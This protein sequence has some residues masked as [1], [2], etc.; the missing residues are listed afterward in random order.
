[1]APQW[2][3]DQFTA[4]R[5]SFMD[6]ALP[7]LKV[8]CGFGSPLR[9]LAWFLVFLALLALTINDIVNLAVEY[10]KYPDSLNIKYEEPEGGEDMPMPAVT[11]CNLNPYKWHDFCKKLELLLGS[12]QVLI[13]NTTYVQ[14]VRLQKD[15]CKTGLTED[16]RIPVWNL[17]RNHLILM[18]FFTEWSGALQRNPSTEEDMSSISHGLQDM[19]ELASFDDAC[20]IFPGNDTKEQCRVERE[21]LEPTPKMYPRYGK[22]LCFFCNHT[23]D[24]KKIVRM[25]DF[26]GPHKGLMLVLKVGDNEYLPF[27]VEAGFVIA[28]HDQGVEVDFTKDGVFIQPLTT[29]YIGVSRRV[30]K[31]LAE[32]Y[33]NPCRSDWPPYLK[34]LV[35]DTKKYTASECREVC[36]Q[37][38]IQTTLNCTSLAY[39]IS[40]VKD[41]DGYKDFRLQTCGPS[42]D[43]GMSHIRRGMYYR[44]VDC[45]CKNVCEETNFD[46]TTSSLSWHPIVQAQSMEDKDGTSMAQVYVYMQSNLIS[47]RTKVGKMDVREFVSGIGSIMGMYLGYSFLFC[48]NILDV[49]GLRLLFVDSALPGLK[50]ICGFGSPARRAAWLLVFLALFGLTIR[51]IINLATDFY[52]YPDSLNIKYEEPEGGLQMPMPA[53]TVCSLNPY[54]WDLFC[55]DIDELLKLSVSLVSEETQANLT[56]MRIRFC[57]EDGELDNSDRL[58]VWNLTEEYMGHMQE[59]TEWS[60]ALQRSS[61]SADKMENLTSCASETIKLATFDGGFLTEC[62]S[63]KEN[64]TDAERENCRKKA[65]HNPEPSGRMFPRYGRCFCFFCNYTKNE[66]EKIRQDSFDG[67]QNGLLLV[68]RVAEESYLP[69]I[70]EAGFIVAIH[71]QGVEVDFTKDGVFVQPLTTTFIGVQR[72][73]LHRLP[74]P[75]QNPCRPDWPPYLIDIVGDSNKYTVFQCRDYCHQFWI[76]K[77]VR[78]TSLKRFILKVKNESSPTGFSENRLRECKRQDL[79]AVRKVELAIKN[80]EIDCECKSVCGETTFDKSISSLAWHPQS[81]LESEENATAGT[82]SKVYVYMQSNLMNNRTKVPKIN[83]REFVSGIG[84]IMG[85][86]LGYSFLFCFNILDVLGRGALD[87]YHAYRR[88]QKRRLIQASQ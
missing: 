31:R 35:E 30:L 87:T 59:F 83:T 75:Y 76:Q 44:T 70:V 49:L 11:V 36:A 53:I 38:L 23:T 79:P 46:K 51:D 80:R 13:Q 5:L 69:F 81:Q 7:G 68:L 10:Y 14:M 82:A 52:R 1:M 63:S 2:L 18:H 74:E 8:I 25:A 37:Y 58:P 78:C 28:I 41:G 39:P 77:E 65:R 57:P 17:T 64:K 50:V 85:M 29:T 48:W 54:K 40:R 22:C 27:I 12:S 73:I 6:S 62:D 86:Y 66:S 60:L 26:D 20:D 33:Q 9:R 3:S 84:S 45:D 61:A 47:N 34:R 24:P 43:E 56:A 32:P 88:E 67:P 19:V 72:R 4:M 16:V 71:D 42:F 21:L 55:K 15:Y